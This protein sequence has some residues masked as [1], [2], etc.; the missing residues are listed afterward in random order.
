MLGSNSPFTAEQRKYFIVVK[1]TKLT[2]LIEMTGG[3][4]V[5][6]DESRCGSEECTLEVGGREVGGVALKTY[7]SK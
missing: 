7:F 6:E 5:S 2:F 1:M 3:G 4:F